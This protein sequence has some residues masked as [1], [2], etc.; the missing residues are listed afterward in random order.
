MGPY[1][2]SKH[3]EIKEIAQKFIDANTYSALHFQDMSY[4][5]LGEA[6]DRA[7]L[8]ASH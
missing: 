1:Q 2:V 4:N 3:P 7:G 5:N 8:A 6:K